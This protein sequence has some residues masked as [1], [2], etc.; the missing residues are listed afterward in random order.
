MTINNIENNKNI[1]V[2]SALAFGDFIIDCNFLK[3]KP[4][5][6]ILTPSYNKE[7][8]D[9]ICPVNKVVFFNLKKTN[10]PPLLFNLKSF[11]IY[12]ILT[13][14]FE[15]TKAINFFKKE[16]NIIFN[17]DSY[18]WKII[19]FLGPFNYIRKKEENIYDSYELFIGQKKSTSTRQNKVNAINIFPDSRQESKSIPNYTLLDICTILNKNKIKFIIYSNR[20]S[21]DLD[22]LISI[23]SLTELIEIIKDSEAVISADSL[24]IHLSEYYGVTNFVIAPKINKQLFP[25]NILKNKNWATFGNLSKFSNWIQNL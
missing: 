22:N 23:N 9:L 21:K 18:K 12:G 8:C 19:N 24:P 11:K 7:L 14:W 10:I 20:I 1:C 2:L 5:I 3:H 16:Y 17:S 15:L 6:I 25:N 4:E 13:S